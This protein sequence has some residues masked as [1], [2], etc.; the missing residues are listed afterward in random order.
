MPRDPDDI[1]A[2]ARERAES[3]RRQIHELGDRD[4]VTQTARGRGLGV[5]LGRLDRHGT[6]PARL[7]V[8]LTDGRIVP[9]F[10]R[11]A[12]A[13]TVAGII[14]G[15]ADS[16]ADAASAA[17]YGEVEPSEVDSWQVELLEDWPS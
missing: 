1:A 7:S 14:A 16:I 6:G 11:G 15:G 3:I 4:I 13:Q 2:E 10:G 5:Q 17:G 12:N 8:K 9:V